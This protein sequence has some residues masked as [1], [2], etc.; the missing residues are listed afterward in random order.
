MPY[1]SITLSFNLF[2]NRPQVSN[3]FITI[4]DPVATQPRVSHCPVF[5]EEKCIYLLLNG[6]L[7]E[8]FVTAHSSI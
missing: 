5:R 7:K 6:L 8:L 3:E 2:V 4:C 1:V